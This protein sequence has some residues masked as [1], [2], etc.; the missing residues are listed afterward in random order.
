MA[1]RLEQATVTLVAAFRESGVPLL[2]GDALITG[3]QG[4]AAKR[5]LH[6]VSDNFVV[7]WTGLMV[8]AELVIQ[9][10]YD[11][12]RNQAATLSAVKDFLTNYPATRLPGRVYLIGW[13]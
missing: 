3:P 5:K 13:V 4:T 9:A 12:F 1:L 11:R 2:I 8:S 10:V 7:G 6:R